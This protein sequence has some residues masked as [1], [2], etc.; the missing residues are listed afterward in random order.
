MKR[1]LCFLIAVFSAATL[2]AVSAGADIVEPGRRYAGEVMLEF[3]AIGASFTLPAG[4]IAVLPEGAELLIMQNEATGAYLFAT[5]DEMTVAEALGVM[6]APID[7]GDGVVLKPEGDVTRDGNQLRNVY[8]VSG[9][10]GPLFGYVNTIIGDAGIGVSFVGIGPPD[11]TEALKSVVERVGRSLSLVPVA[12][13]A[14]A[15]QGGSG[16]WQ[17][18]LAGRKL[19]HFFTRTGYTEEDYMWLCA[20]GRFYHSTQAGGF[21]GGASGAFASSYGGRWSA[22][23]DAGAGTLVLRYNDGQ[24]ATYALSWDGTKLFLDGKRYFR[25][26]TDCR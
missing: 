21:G 11:D 5:G 8:A 6:G 16:T 26:A 10:E 23:G 1:V 17:D 25:E 2:L 12:P 19:T 22:T 24:S 20:D 3:P 4:W 7:L 18:E 14:Q 9:G 15:Q 13:V